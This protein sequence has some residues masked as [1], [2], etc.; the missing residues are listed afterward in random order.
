MK[1]LENIILRTADTSKLPLDKLEEIVDSL[2]APGLIEVALYSNTS[3]AGDVVFVLKW[4]TE[5]PQ[6][7]GSD[8]SIA[9]KQ[10][11][12]KQG[13]VDHSVWTYIKGGRGLS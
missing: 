11:L 6:A 10:E 3:I 7:W 12:M 2:S 5:K 9:V 4:D 1:W 8:L 13:L